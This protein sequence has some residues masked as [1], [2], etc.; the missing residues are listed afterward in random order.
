MADTQISSI[1]EKTSSEIFRLRK[2]LEEK[3]FEISMMKQKHL[4]DIDRM[5]RDVTEAME[6][7]NQG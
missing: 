1:A 6:V 2:E 5:K 7:K 4:V 3:N